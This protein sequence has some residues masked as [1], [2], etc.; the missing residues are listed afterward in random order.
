MKL[1]N[2]VYIMY[3]ILLKIGCHC[4]IRELLSG[5]MIIP[6][7]L[8]RLIYEIKQALQKKILHVIKLNFWFESCKTKYLEKILKEA[9][10]TVFINIKLF[11]GF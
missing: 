11:T 3:N 4:G 9:T 5:F 6:S 2:F 10:R 1:C 8:K 7:L